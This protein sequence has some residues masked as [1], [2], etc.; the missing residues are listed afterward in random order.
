[1]TNFLVTMPT[2]DFPQFP[3]DRGSSQLNNR[4]EGDSE[5]EMDRWNEEKGSIK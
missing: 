2:D 3:V 4:K 1:M 5:G